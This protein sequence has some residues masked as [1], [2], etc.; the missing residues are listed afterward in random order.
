MVNPD[1][2][3]AALGLTCER[4]GGIAAGRVANFAN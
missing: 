4:I 2:T 3:D 1:R